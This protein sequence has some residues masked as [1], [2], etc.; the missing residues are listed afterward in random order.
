[1]SLQVPSYPSRYSETD[2][3]DAY[4]WIVDLFVS[5]ADGEGKITLNVHPESSDYQKT[6]IDQVAIVLGRDGFPDLATVLAENASHFNAIRQYL[7]DKIKDL[8]A[9]DGATDVP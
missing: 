9:F 2:L 7:Y 6:P 5:F 8:P 1:M 4:A 3:V